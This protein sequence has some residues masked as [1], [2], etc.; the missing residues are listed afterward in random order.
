MT[1]GDQIQVRLRG[2]IP[3]TAAEV[4]II[5]RNGDSLAL[6][7][8]EGLGSPEGFGVNHAT[9]KMQLILLRPEGGAFYQDI[10]GSSWWE[11]KDP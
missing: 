8:A 4:E 10:F 3:W 2:A 9:G 6:S 1:K 7:A 5:S 11:V